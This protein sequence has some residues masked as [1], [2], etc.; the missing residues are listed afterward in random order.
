[1]IELQDRQ[2]EEQTVR[3]KWT[4]ERRKG[5]KREGELKEIT[6]KRGMRGDRRRRGERREERVDQRKVRREAGRRVNWK[7]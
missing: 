2:K 1:M 7:K 5:I 3:D 6:W 4:K